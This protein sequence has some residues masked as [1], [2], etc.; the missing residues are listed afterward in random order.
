MFKILNPT[1]F[2]DAIHKKNIHTPTSTFED[3][4]MYVCMYVGTFNI[5]KMLI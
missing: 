3:R 5:N 2:D 4:V 1:K